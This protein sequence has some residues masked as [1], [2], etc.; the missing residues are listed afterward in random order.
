MSSYSLTHVSDPD[1]VRGLT[2][3]VAQDRSA[4][5]VVLAHLA[6]FDARRLYVP[7]AFPST[8][9]YCVHELH[10][11]EDAAYRRIQAARAARQFPAIFDALAQG[12]LHLTA[13]NLLAPHLTP[14]NAGA[15]LDAAAHRTKSEVEQLLAERFPRSETLALVQALPSSPPPPQD[16]RSPVPPETC[17]SDGRGVASGLALA[18]VPLAPRPSTTPV[19]PERFLVQFTFG[20]SEHDDL[21]YAQALL[22]HVIPSGD[23]AQVIARALKALICQQE[24]RKFG[25]TSGLRSS[26]RRATG[27][28]CI[29][30]HV[31][32][33][34]W[35]RDGGR[36][37][38]VSP[39]GRRCPARTLLE[40][41][42]LDPVALGGDATVE[43]VTLKC[44]A[45]NQ[46]AAECAFGS[47]FMRH[48]REEA[49]RARVEARAAAARQTA[50][51]REQAA[52]AAEK[53]KELDVVPALR[54]LGFRADEARRAAAHCDKTLPDGPLEE[55]LRTALRFLSPPAR[56]WRPAP[57]GL[58][59]AP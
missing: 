14:E 2:S 45:H 33:A 40:F 22:S 49:R 34:V 29:P 31:R 35:E 4:T 6:E 37:T 39:T 5:V 55:R 50:E 19:A 57:N 47:E 9:L 56:R 30:A 43:K 38:F 21:Q 8:Y 54:N 41:D 53:A 51:A 23:L 52:A 25:G 1:L 11:S 46:Y 24:K 44:R 36:C 58:A 7:A 20:K 59:P 10:L 27:K 13:V 28:R 15:L 48:K 3:A 16:H 12:R 26:P 18:Q 17:A 42:H 32:H